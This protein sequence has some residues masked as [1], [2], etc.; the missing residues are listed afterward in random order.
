V[1]KHSREPA[2][3]RQKFK[4]DQQP[5]H[6]RFPDNCSLGSQGAHSPSCTAAFLGSP[7]LSHQHMG[8]SNIFSSN[9]SFVEHFISKKEEL[10]FKFYLSLK[11][12]DCRVARTAS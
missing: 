8:Q 2:L 11:P 10:G 3:R 7:N 5:M 1:R 4:A 12:A 9:A 6:I